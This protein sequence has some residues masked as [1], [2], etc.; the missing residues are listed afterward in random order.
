MHTANS[1]N[2]S[3]EYNYATTNNRLLSTEVGQTTVSYTYNEH[4]L[5]ASMPHL[6]A[7]DWDFA[8]RL[9]HITRGTTEAYYNYDGSGQRTRKVVEKGNTVEES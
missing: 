7:M 9:S 3:R 5:M 6:Q 8:E 1:G 2:W 4:G